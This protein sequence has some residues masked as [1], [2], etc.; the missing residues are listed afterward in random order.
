[1]MD[2]NW[3][4]W[5]SIQEKAN[6]PWLNS[7]NT[8]NKTKRANNFSKLRTLRKSNLLKNGCK[9]STESLSNIRR[10]NLKSSLY[11][12]WISASTKINR[13][14]RRAKLLTIPL[15]IS[16]PPLIEISMIQAFNPNWEVEP[17]WERRSPNQSIYPPKKFICKDY[18]LHTKCKEIRNSERQRRKW[19]QRPI[20]SWIKTTKFMIWIFEFI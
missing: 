17:D 18:K 9:T 7:S 20:S 10:I 1:M 8:L 16:T 12:P 14:N 19:W 4:S 15:S 3:R 5:L 6:R 11:P 2:R 13:S